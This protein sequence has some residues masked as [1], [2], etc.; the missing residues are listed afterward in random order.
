MPPLD[1]IQH[2]QTNGTIQPLR[3][4]DLCRPLLHCRQTPGTQRFC[5]P[6]GQPQQLF[7]AQK[8]DEQDQLIRATSKVICESIL[9]FFDAYLKGDEPHQHYLGKRSA[10]SQSKPPGPI[11]P[12][13]PG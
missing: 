5:H 13:L 8:P 2:G 7:L 1:H 10:N 11:Y 6:Q 9:A 3:C 4:P 12:G